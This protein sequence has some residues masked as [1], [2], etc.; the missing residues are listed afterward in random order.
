M[1][2]NGTDAKLLSAYNIGVGSNYQ[3][4]AS[5][6]PNISIS[7][8]ANTVPFTSNPPYHNQHKSWYNDISAF[9]KKI[10]LPTKTKVV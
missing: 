6:P 1:Q 7:T 3:L 5:W 2:W 4:P 10:C 8:D 9:K